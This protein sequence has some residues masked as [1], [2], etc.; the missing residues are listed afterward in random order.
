MTVNDNRHDAE[1]S[2]H[3]KKTILVLSLDGPDYD[4]STASR[5]TYHYLKLFAD[6]GLQV[7]FAG[8]QYLRLEPYAT[9]LEQVGIRVLHGK[10]KKELKKWIEI[11]G[12]DIDYAYIIFPFIAEDYLEYF[13]KY[14]HAKIFYNASDL[15]YLREM[16]NYQI[17][18]KP[19]LL[20]SANRWKKREYEIFKK[21][22]VIHVVSAYEKEILTKKFPMKKVRSIPVCMYDIDKKEKVNAFEKREG[23]LFVGTFT[24]KPNI[25]G[26]MWF[27]KS[28]FP[29]IVAVLPDLKL[30]IVG[31]KPTQEILKMR[32]RNVVVTGYV[33]DKKLSAFYQNS[34]L[35]IAPLRF[36][37]GVKGKVVEAMYNQVPTV[38]T[39]MGSEGLVKIEKYLSIA[40]EPETFAN[41]VLHVYRNKEVWTRRSE[42][43][44]K[45]IK[46]YFTKQSGRK[47]LML[48][49]EI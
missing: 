36:G 21:S 31:Y 14:T 1:R 44:L 28:V 29:R 18:K 17:E 41:E 23:L 40:D 45:Y 13:K 4:K 11:H 20:E 5:M 22:D 2:N 19:A 47:Q 8:Y 42:E 37:A 16:R 27:M 30:Y 10:D 12:K 9:E 39:S 24:H 6:M 7:I 34:R 32:S 3:R 33:T 49:I 35:V 48:D 26:I 46:T 15:F 25:D 43:S 38:T